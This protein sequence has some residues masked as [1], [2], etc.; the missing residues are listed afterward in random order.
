MVQTDP[1]QRFIGAL[2]GCGLGCAIE[3]AK[4]G[5]KAFARHDVVAHGQMG[6]DGILLKDDA[7]VQPRFHR[8]R[9]AGDADLAFCWPL[10][11]KQQPEKGRFPAARR[12]YNRD[13]LAFVDRNI[14]AFKDRTHPVALKDIGGGDETHS[15]ASVQGNSLRDTQRN[16]RS[17][18]K[19]RS[20]IQMT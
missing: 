9:G 2:A 14:H 12:A 3:S 4:A 19:A 1:C 5:A 13:E 17:I 18:R 6:E 11:R 7:P 8:G 20:V 15:P 10:L 16:A